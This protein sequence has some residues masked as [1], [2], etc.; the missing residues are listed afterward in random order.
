VEPNAANVISNDVRL[1]VDARAP[2]RERLARLVADIHAA[3]ATGQVR[4]IR[5]TDP[6]RMADDVRREL[7]TVLTELGLPAPELPSF[8]GHDA[9]VLSTAGV[10]CG[11]LFVRSR[12]GGVSHSPREHSDRHDLELAVDALA[13][14]LTRLARVEPVASSEPPSRANAN[15]QRVKRVT[16][17]DRID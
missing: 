13:H 8:A 9:G 4:V 11:M 12:S 2:E 1:I 6:V 15:A 14:A 7:V 17:T 3:G 16:G 10:P 5:G